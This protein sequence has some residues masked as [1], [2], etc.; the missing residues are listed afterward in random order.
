MVSELGWKIVLKYNR[1][2]LPLVAH[3]VSIRR[4]DAGAHWM[5]KSSTRP[6]IRSPS[7]ALVSVCVP[8]WGVF[9]LRVELLV[10]EGSRRP[11]RLDHCLPEHRSIRG[12]VKSEDVSGLYVRRRVR[13]LST[14]PGHTEEAPKRARPP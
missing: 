8:E 7:R 10:E 11:V 13:Y 4:G 14:M 12:V 1:S 5:V 9:F 2:G 6:P 3:G